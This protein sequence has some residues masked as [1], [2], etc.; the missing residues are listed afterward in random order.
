LTFD[1]NILP[2]IWI[3]RTGKIMKRHRFQIILVL[4]LVISSLVM[5]LIHYAVFKDLHHIAIFML[6]DIAIMPIEVLVVTL[7]IHRL[8]Q[9]REKQA[10][11]AKLN[12]VI[13]AFFSEVGEELLRAFTDFDKKINTIRDD[14]LTEHDWTNKHVARLN[15]IVGHYEPDIDSRDCNLDSFKAFLFKRRV[16][17]LRLLENPNL[18]EHESFTDLLWAVSHLQ[19]ELFFREDFS[20]LPESD[21][22]HLTIDM[23]R[24]YRAVLKEWVSYMK[25]LSDN[26]PYLFSLAS[27][28]NPFDENASAIVR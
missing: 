25:H 3:V 24:A 1:K 17:M 22:A 26:Y 23:K 8:L 2:Q 14:L 7:I 4:S 28:I 19:E 6:G 10:L 18:L 21:L 9:V 15:R 27:R 5:Y 12:I 20:K 13:G 16:F 11:M